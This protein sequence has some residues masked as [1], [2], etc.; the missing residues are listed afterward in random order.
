MQEF[1][2]QWM[3]PSASAHGPSLDAMNAI[4]HWLMAILFVGWLAYFLFVLFKFSAKRN[5]KANYDGTKSHFSMYIEVGIAV[6][7]VIILIGF[8][9]PAWA[10]WVEPHDPGDD[11][12]VVRVVAQQFAWN[13]HYP[14]PD[15]VFG[16]TSIDL[17]DEATNPLGLD[18][19]DPMAVDD[20]VSINQLHLP[21]DRPVTIRLSS[22]DVIHSFS[23]PIMRVKQ[24]AIPGMEI[25]VSFTPVKTNEGELWNIACAQLCGLSHYSMKGYVTVETET[26]FDAWLAKKAPAPVEPAG[27]AVD[28][29]GEAAGEAVEMD[30]EAVDHSDH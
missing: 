11:P 26:E 5:P 7:E 29:G 30:A 18:R 20:I 21:V 2:A 22:K 25:P 15:G 14:G 16:T 12:L 3:I 19:S 8:A 27:S 13:M 28:E 1:L 23:L 24:D 6:V 4:V 10:S 9:L 17:I